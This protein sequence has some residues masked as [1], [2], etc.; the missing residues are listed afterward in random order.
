MVKWCSVGNVTCCILVRDSTF[1]RSGN[2][3]AIRDRGF[4]R[5]SRL[6]ASHARIGRVVGGFDEGC[7]KHKSCLSLALAGGCFFAR[8]HLIMA[9][10]S[11]PIIPTGAWLKTTWRVK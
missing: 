3:R 4:E 9:T 10:A 1:A 5:F 2:F 11:M 6:C 7:N 8:G